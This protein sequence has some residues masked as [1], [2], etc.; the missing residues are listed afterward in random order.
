MNSKILLTVFVGLLVFSTFLATTASAEDFWSGLVNGIQEWFR[1]SPFGGMFDTPAKEVSFAKI[2][3]YPQNYTITPSDTFNIEST[4]FSVSGFRGI[5]NY[6][7]PSGH[8][9]FN[10][11]TDSM[12][13]TGYLSDNTTLTNLKIAR[14][15]LNHVHLDITTG[16]S[17]WMTEDGTADFVDFVGGAKL[18]ADH[19]ELSGNVTKI[20]KK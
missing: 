20:T 19:I 8:V 5:V 7:P 14:F 16:N 3:F 12:K 15:T 10:Q 13:I 4:H 18:F 6:D 1:I 9:T 2:I 11:E 17:T